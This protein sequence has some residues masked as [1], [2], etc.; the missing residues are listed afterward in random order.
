MHLGADVP[1]D[2]WRVAFEATGAGLAVIGV[3]GA[4][5]VAAADRVVRSLLALA[6]PPIAVLGGRRAR[7][8][9]GVADGVVLLPDPIDEAIAVIL[10]LAGSAA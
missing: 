1:L 7:E 9:P 5:D 4:P 8:L 2:S 3:V 6:R 10:G